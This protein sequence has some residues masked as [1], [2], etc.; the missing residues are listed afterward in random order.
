MSNS[1]VNQLIFTVSTFYSLYR[2]EINKQAGVYDT[3]NW[4]H[5]N[6][7]MIIDFFHYLVCAAIYAMIIKNVVYRFVKSE[8]WILISL[9]ILIFIAGVTFKACILT[10]ARNSLLGKR[11]S[12]KIFSLMPERVVKSICFTK[13]IKKSGFLYGVPIAYLFYRLL[14]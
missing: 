3:D 6:Q 12:T 2:V 7:A 10:H 4:N 8:V 1:S 5:H 14:R 13:S 9:L 11:Y